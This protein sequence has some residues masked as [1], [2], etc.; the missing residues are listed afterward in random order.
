[1][2]DDMKSDYMS[3]IIQICKLSISKTFTK[4]EFTICLIHG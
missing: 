1:M 4:V 2:L 3:V